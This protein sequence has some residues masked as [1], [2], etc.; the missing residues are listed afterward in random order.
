MAAQNNNRFEIREDMVFKVNKNKSPSGVKLRS[1]EWAI[2]TQLNGEKSVAQVGETLALN[3][4]ETNAMF[5]RLME[6]GLL[7]LVGSPDKDPYVSPD[8]LD[9]LE[10]KFTIYVGPIASIILDDLL[11]ELKRNRENLELGQL[12][13]L[14]ELISHEISSEDKRHEFR[15]QMLQKI[16]GLINQ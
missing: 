14:T 12:P 5:N 13:L 15:K 6:E 1:L 16:K 3:P 7:E 4:L 2:I 9:D 10:Y 8:V 11:G